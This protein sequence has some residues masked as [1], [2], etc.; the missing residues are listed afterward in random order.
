[1]SKSLMDTAV[2]WEVTK[3]LLAEKHDNEMV[4]IINELDE[5]IDKTIRN[6]MHI[7]QRVSFEI[8]QR[9]EKSHDQ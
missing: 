8:K 6:A 3:Y 7:A 4:L 1:M 5:M 2:T 9:E